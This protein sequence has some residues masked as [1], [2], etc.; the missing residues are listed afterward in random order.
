MANYSTPASPALAPPPIAGPS[1]PDHAAPHGA[2]S[3]GRAMTAAILVFILATCALGITAVIAPKFEDM[4]RDFGVALPYV[5]RVFLA[6]ARA[7][8]TPIGLISAAAAIGLLCTAAG[9]FSYSRRW[10]F[11]LV[12]VL[13]IVGFL[14]YGG[15][16]LLAMFGPNVAMIESLQQSGTP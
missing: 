16:F 1:S 5:T 11:A 2:A 4:F 14:L 15:L 12:I 3:L 13:A 6:I 8:T 9:T 10:A 7:L